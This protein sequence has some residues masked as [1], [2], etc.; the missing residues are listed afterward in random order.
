VSPPDRGAA[1]LE[2]IVALAIL[3]SAGVS[4]VALLGGA[5]RAIGDARERERVLAA[6]ERVLAAMTLLRRHELD[7]RIGRHEVGEFVVH[8]QRP[9]RALYRLAIAETRSAHVENLVTVVYRP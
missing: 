6:E 3:A 8:V 2:V 1:L 7:Q 9:E 4:T 5:T